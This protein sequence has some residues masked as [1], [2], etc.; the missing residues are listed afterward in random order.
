MKIGDLPVLQFPPPRSQFQLM[1]A[2]NGKEYSDSFKNYNYHK[3]PEYSHTQKSD[4]IIL[5]FE[6]CG[7]TIM[8]PNDADGMANSVD[9][10]WS[11]LFA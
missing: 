5:T 3:V 9:P 10:D 6:L 11:T 1:P 7:L 4:V 2:V 8:C